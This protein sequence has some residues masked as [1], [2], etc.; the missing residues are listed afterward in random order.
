MRLGVLVD[1]VGRRL[2]ELIAPATSRT[3]RTR[4]QLS[5]LRAAI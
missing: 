1:V 4:E 2:D 5:V 3:R